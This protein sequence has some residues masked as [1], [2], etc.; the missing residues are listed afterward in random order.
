[1]SLKREGLEVKERP[2]M[3]VSSLHKPISQI[4]LWFVQNPILAGAGS[5]VFLLFLLSSMAKVTFVHFLSWIQNIFV[6]WFSWFYVLLF[7]SA[8]CFCLYLA[9]GPYRKKRLGH[10]NKP[11]YNNWTWIAML[12]SAG[13]GTG[14]VF[15]G[16]Y[17][18]LYH[19]F[20]PPQGEGGTTD[21]LSL[22]FQLTFL[23]WGFSGWAVYALMGLAMAYFCFCKN[24][25]LRVSSMLAPLFSH[26]LKG[27]W[28]Y[29]VDI[30]SVVVI[31][32]GVATTLGRGAL[33]INS[34]FKE[35]FGIPYSAFIQSGIILLITGMATASLLSGLNK[36]IR[37]FSELNMFVCLLLLLFILFAGPTVLLLN[38]FVEHFG[39]YLQ[40][41]ISSMTW[42]HSLGSVEWRSQWTILYWAWWL[43]WAPFVGL[44]I[45]RIS[46]GRTVQ[47]LILGALIAP[48][49][50]SAIWFTVLGGTAIQGHIEGTMDFQSLLKSE[51]SLTLFAFLKHLPWT[52]LVSTLALLTLVV[53]F[54]TSSDSASYVIHHI[55]HTKKGL[56]VK[57]PRLSKVYWSVLE[58]GLAMALI[59]FGGMTALQLLVIIMSFPFAILFCLI[60]Y[61]FFKEIK[62]ELSTKCP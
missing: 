50:L 4:K 54:V 38:S 17:E 45:A 30:L 9:F 51:Y 13:M 11:K 60:C 59:Y 3:T 16:V 56:S 12:F 35:L 53:F 62:K 44:F 49:L 31:L 18:P 46:E 55:S 32:M 26:K 19:Y 22:S 14:L 15:S 57:Y 2:V 23:H 58:G 6:L 8:F 61:S 28:M 48:T 33:Q 40:G 29:V 20:Y 43:A 37:L 21:S 47:E 52:G 1:M 7:F 10:L 5:F 27:G 24:Y 41:L 34:G 25:N 42:V 39:A 36:G